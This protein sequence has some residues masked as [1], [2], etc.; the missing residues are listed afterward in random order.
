M[1]TVNERGIIETPNIVVYNS[2]R[3]PQRKG[4]EVDT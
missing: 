1:C 3:K 2:Q 4:E